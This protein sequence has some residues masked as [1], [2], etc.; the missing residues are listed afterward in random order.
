M[1]VQ[2]ENEQKV[3]QRTE[4]EPCAIAPHTE[5]RKK[6]KIVVALVSVS[7]NIIE[8]E[9]ETT[10]IFKGCVKAKDTG[11]RVLP[12]SFGGTSYYG[13]CDVGSSI[14]VIPYTFFERIHNAICP[15]NLEPNEMTIKLVDGTFRKPC[16]ILSDVHVILVT[17]IYPVDLVVMEISK[18]DHCPIIF[19][20]TFLNTAGVRID[21]NKE[22]VS[23]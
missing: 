7:N 14:N 17:F 23:L 19:V 4:V 22:I 10:S 9:K 12:C 21:C 18:D 8:M 13:L 16:G 2:L 11:K 5:P 20:R 1:V 6:I 3:R 15:I